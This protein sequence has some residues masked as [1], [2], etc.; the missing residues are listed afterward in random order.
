VLGVLGLLWLGLLRWLLSL[1]LVGKSRLLRDVQLLRRRAWARWRQC[2]RRLRLER[3][4]LFP[5]ATVR[6]GVS[7]DLVV[8]GE[9]FDGEIKKPRQVELPGFFVLK[10]VVWLGIWLVGG[11]GSNSRPSH[12]ECKNIPYS[13]M[14]I[15]NYEFIC[16]NNATSTND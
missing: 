15:A 2:E 11:G 14:L 16:H 3:C 13:S 12:C 9:A 10:L 7:S 6:G 5:M 1:L 4:P 8:C